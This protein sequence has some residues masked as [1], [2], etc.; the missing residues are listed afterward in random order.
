MRCW[1]YH[2]VLAYGIPE[3]GQHQSLLPKK[4]AD[5]HFI[6]WFCKSL[7]YALRQMPETNQKEYLRV[8]HEERESGRCERTKKGRLDHSK[9][10]PRQHCK[11]H[12]M[13][14]W[15]LSITSPR[16]GCAS[17]AVTSRCW[18]RFGSSL[19]M[20]GIPACGTFPCVYLMML[21]PPHLM[22]NNI[23]RSGVWRTRCEVELSGSEVR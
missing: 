4:G 10:S 9:R 14:S 11:F 18:E 16:L 23:M 2:L 20:S 3:K 15:G 22:G 1:A 13:A 12:L 6:L 8:S 7:G 19:F 5:T 17:R 21:K